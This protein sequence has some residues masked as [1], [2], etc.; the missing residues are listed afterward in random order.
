MHRTSIRHLAT[1]GA[2][3]LTVLGAAA[4][5]GSEPVSPLPANAAGLPSTG[6]P[7]QTPTMTP[8]ASTPPAHAPPAGSKP[9]KTATPR[10]TTPRPTH[11]SACMGAI[12]YD[13]DLHTNELAL[14]RSMCFRVGAVLRL[15][16]IGP[17]LVTAEPASLVR[18]NYEAGV[19]DIRFVGA[20][21]VT[22][23]IPQDGQIY[24]ITVVVIR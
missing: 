5:C 24:T 7:S 14:V 18:Q 20:G 2:L 19:V 4:A 6:T 16:G 11:S 13:L 21:T 1:L 17:G 23:T 10:P 9:T 12:R 22:V 15:Q 8:G 3:A